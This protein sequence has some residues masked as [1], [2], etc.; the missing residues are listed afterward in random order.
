MRR[1]GVDIRD[2]RVIA[3]TDSVGDSRSTMKTLCLPVLLVALVVLHSESHPSHGRHKKSRENLKKRLQ[4]AGLV[5]LTIHHEKVTD[6][7]FV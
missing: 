4:V 7:S 1:F 6:G 3:S 2:R 5:N